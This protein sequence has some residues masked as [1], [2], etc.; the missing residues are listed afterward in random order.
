MY[1]VNMRTFIARL[2]LLVAMLFMPLGMQAAAA[3]APNHST[4][5]QMPTGHCRD[6][7]PAHDMK[8]GIAE[9]TMACAAALPAVDSP[10]ANP[11]QIVAAQALPATAQ[12][13]DGIDPETATPPPKAS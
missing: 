2:A 11:P 1:E 12:R 10:R 9:C 7:A 8:S 6:R 3:S 4:M 5:T 13:L